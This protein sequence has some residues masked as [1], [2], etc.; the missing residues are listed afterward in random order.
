MRTISSP[1]RG[2]RRPDEVSG[3]RVGLKTP[4]PAEGPDFPRSG[5]VS[6]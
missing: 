2:E 6:L 4:F 3:G 5:E 1:G